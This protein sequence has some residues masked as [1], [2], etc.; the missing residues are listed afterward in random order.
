MN[1]RAFLTELGK[2]LSG[3]SKQDAIER[4]N[5]YSEMIDDRI[6]EG[7]SEEEA[8]K[9]I[10]SIDEIVETIKSEVKTTHTR[11]TKRNLCGWE[12]ALLIIG[13]PLWI[14]LA[15][16]AVAV[17]ISLYAALWSIVVSVWAAFISLA[18]A[19]PA[20][21]IGGAVLC[22]TSSAAV[23]FSLIGAGIL[24]AGLGI[25]LF[26]ASLIAT[27]GAALFTKITALAI[28]GIFRKKE[29]L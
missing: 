18:V 8:V 3:V 16:I 7:L 9:A 20:G 29:E 15:I 25:F 12:I 17:A 21:V 24:C 4:L 11:E 22:F 19:A 2:R 1:K 14:A 5:F 28:L 13:S 26:F 6:E 23:G 27:K 10:G